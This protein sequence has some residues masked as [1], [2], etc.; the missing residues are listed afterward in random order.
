MYGKGHSWLAIHGNG[1]TD[2]WVTGMCVFDTDTSKIPEEKLP[3]VWKSGIR[4]CCKKMTGT[5]WFQNPSIVELPDS[6]KMKSHFILNDGSTGAV[7]LKE[8]VYQ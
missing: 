1:T 7:E 5:V 2:G 4:L 8:P 6:V 3:D